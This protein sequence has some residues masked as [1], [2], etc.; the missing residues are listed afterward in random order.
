MRV[1]G[2]G[3]TLTVHANHVVFIFIEPKGCIGTKIY[4]CLHCRGVVVVEWELLDLM[5]QKLAIVIPIALRFEALTKII[6]LN[7]IS[8]IRVQSFRCGDLKLSLGFRPA[9]A[10]NF[11]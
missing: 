8:G 11:P 7:D 4:Q 5:I 6:D 2:S 9:L 10:L 3:L 1:R